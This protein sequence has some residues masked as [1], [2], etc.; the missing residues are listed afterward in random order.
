[1]RRAAALALAAT[2]AAT[3][4]ATT[5]ASRDHASRSTSHRSCALPS[6]RA[7]RVRLQPR[8]AILVYRCPLLRSVRKLDDTMRRPNHARRVHKLVPTTTTTAAA[9]CT[10]AD[11]CTSAV[12]RPP[13]AHSGRLHRHVW[14]VWRGQSSRLSVLQR[15]RCVLSSEPVVRAVHLRCER[16]SCRVGVRR[17]SSQRHAQRHVAFGDERHGGERR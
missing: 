3:A 7:A 8:S 11:A 6:L 1:M 4:V 12:D 17:A 16:L 14:H 13:R 10:S 9:A 15:D 2:A 5:A